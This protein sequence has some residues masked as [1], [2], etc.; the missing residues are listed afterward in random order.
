MMNELVAA[1]WRDA[2]YYL[3]LFLYLAIIF[4][5]AGILIGWVPA[6]R[7]LWRSLGPG[8]KASDAA[9]IAQGTARFYTRIANRLPFIGTCWALRWSKPF[10]IAISVCEHALFMA[11]IASVRVVQL[12]AE[13]PTELSWGDMALLAGLFGLVDSKRRINRAGAMRPDHTMRWQWYA[14]H[15]ALSATAGAVLLLAIMVN[16]GYLAP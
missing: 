6:T 2:G 10:E 9:A 11:L 4:G 14:L 1:A 8:F 15:F 13:G 16:L 12:W 3:G 7:Q 5:S